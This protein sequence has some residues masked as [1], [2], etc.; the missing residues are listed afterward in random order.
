MG[1]NRRD[2]ASA[3]GRTLRCA[4][5]RLGITQEK[6]AELANLDRAYPSLLERGLRT[7]TLTAYLDISA[8]LNLKPESLVQGTLLRLNSKFSGS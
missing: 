6:L 8:A 7:P 5:N 2:V 4:R 3:F 1:S